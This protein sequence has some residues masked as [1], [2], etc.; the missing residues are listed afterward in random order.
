MPD[1]AFADV[2]SHVAPGVDDGPANGAE[3]QTA[4]AA[5]EAAGVTHLI[6]TPHFS[7]SLTLDADAREQRLSA[8]DEGWTALESLARESHSAIALSRGAEILLDEPRPDLSDPRIRLAGGAFV[9]V[10]FPLGSIPPESPAVLAHLREM[11]W[12]PVLAHPERYSE[13]RLRPH[14]LAAWRGAGAYFQINAGSLL[15]SYG[16]MARLLAYDLLA[17]GWVDM[18]ASDYHG[19][20]PLP[21]PSAWSLLVGAGGERQAE[22]LMVVNPLR[23]LRD[24][25]PLPVEGVRL[26]RGLLERARRLFDQGAVPDLLTRRRPA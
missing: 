11:G 16:R 2:H 8:L 15:G 6:A 24:V 3:S 21:L 1:L 17:R 19:K 12:H 23:V 5:M 18:I 4:L 22:C 14:L 9:L 25:A 13:L 26:R 20:G 10:E 7:A